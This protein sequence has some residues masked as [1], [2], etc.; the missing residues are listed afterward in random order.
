M[1]PGLAPKTLRYDS[2]EAESSALELADDHELR[3]CA[4]VAI[5]TTTL[6]PG[7]AVQAVWTQLHRR[8]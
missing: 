7:Q 6:T 8:P 1:A 2:D 4:D 5:D 3:A